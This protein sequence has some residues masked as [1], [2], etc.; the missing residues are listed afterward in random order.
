M[1]FFSTFLQKVYVCFILFRHFLEKL[2]FINPPA[3][4]KDANLFHRD[5]SRQKEDRKTF[6]DYKL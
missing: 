1:L 4:N 5:E 2:R 3:I 6:L